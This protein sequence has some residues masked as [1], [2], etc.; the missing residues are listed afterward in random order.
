MQVDTLKHVCQAALK[1]E[2]NE[3]TVLY[4]LGMA[5]QYHATSLKVSRQIYTLVPVAGWKCNP[6]KLYGLYV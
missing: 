2:L 3:E 5:D 6:S 1:T 4:L